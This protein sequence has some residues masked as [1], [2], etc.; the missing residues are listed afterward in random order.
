MPPTLRPTAVACG[1]LGLYKT[2]LALRRW[3]HRICRLAAPRHAARQR[4]GT[5]AAAAAAAVVAL[6][7]TVCDMDGY[8]FY[9]NVTSPPNKIVSFFDSNVTV[10]AE[11][12]D[13]LEGCVAFSTDGNMRDSL[14]PKGNWT[15]LQSSTYSCWGLYIK[16]ELTC[17]RQAAAGAPAAAGMGARARR[18]H[19]SELL[20][21]S[22]AGPCH[23]AP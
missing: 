16:S 23:T 1:S 15:P 4:R 20:A 21:S 19:A 13:K 11:Y 12:C 14:L 18:M 6:T 9:P 17:R 7:T 2:S 22:C 5:A 10:M 8:T 3:R